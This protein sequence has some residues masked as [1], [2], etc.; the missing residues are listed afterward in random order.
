[1]VLHIAVTA[2]DSVTRRVS[3]RIFYA[4]NASKTRYTRAQGRGRISE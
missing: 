3:E 1:M 4:R 2:L